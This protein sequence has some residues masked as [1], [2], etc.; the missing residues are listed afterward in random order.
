MKKKDFIDFNKTIIEITVTFLF[1]VRDIEEFLAYK[2][3]KVRQLMLWS[4]V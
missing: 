1:L 3:Y 4:K 2:F